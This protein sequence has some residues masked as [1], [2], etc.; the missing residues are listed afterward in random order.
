VQRAFCWRD[1]QNATCWAPFVLTNSIGSIV[2]EKEH[3]PKEIDGP[4]PSNGHG[5][6]MGII[7]YQ[8]RNYRN[9]TAHICQKLT[10]AQL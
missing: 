8:P 1:M 9:L 2:T 4:V 3:K 7:R 5:L 10:L 6:S